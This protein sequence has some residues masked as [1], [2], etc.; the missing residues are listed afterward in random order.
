MAVSHLS[1]VS[2]SGRDPGRTMG[3]LPDIRTNEKLP[4]GQ[5]NLQIEAKLENLVFLPPKA[6]P[7]DGPCQAMQHKRNCHMSVFIGFRIGIRP[8]NIAIYKFENLSS[9]HFGSR[10]TCMSISCTHAADAALHICSC[11]LS[12]SGLASCIDCCACGCH[13]ALIFMH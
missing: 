8:N 2:L 6:I 1:F 9:N 10:Q 7:E 11:C 5:N 13:H 4:K 3:A 12:G